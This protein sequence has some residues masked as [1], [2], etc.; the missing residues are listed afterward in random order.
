MLNKGKL[1]WTYK[2]SVVI[3]LNENMYVTDSQ[4]GWTR[5][6]PS[7]MRGLYRNVKKQKCKYLTL[8]KVSELLL[9]LQVQ[10]SRARGGERSVGGLQGS[11]HCACQ[12]RGTADERYVLRCGLL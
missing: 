9:L 7:L 11:R 3:I 5:T 12:T 6:V 4:N 8:R 2:V 1:I 10:V